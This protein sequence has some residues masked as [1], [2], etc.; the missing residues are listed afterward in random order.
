MWYLF[1]WL[2]DRLEAFTC[3]LYAPKSSPTK[4]NY[5]RYDMLCAKTG[6]IDSHPLPPCQDCSV[7]HLQRATYQAAI[8][9]RCME[10]DPKVPSP[11]GR[12]WKIEKEEWV[13]QLVVHWMDG[14]PVPQ[15]VPDLLACNCT[16]KCSLPK[17]VCLSNWLKCTDICRLQDCKRTRHNRLFQTPVSQSPWQAVMINDWQK[18]SLPGP[19]LCNPV[20]FAGHND[21][22]VRLWGCSNLT[23]W[24]HLPY[25]LISQC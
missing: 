23:E 11:V 20:C 9:R 19:W 21:T 18:V 16:R 3:R 25:S 13:E 22:D 24:L 2:M 12:G 10:H 4:V 6:E 14:Q 5:L 8:W 1:R 15:A 17:C 7:K